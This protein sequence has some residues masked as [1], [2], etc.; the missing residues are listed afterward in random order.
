M[1]S[2]EK[3]TSQY[4]AQYSHDQSLDDRSSTLM[5]ACKLRLLSV[6]AGAPVVDA[7]SNGTQESIGFTLR[8]GFFHM[9]R[10][11]EALNA[12]DRCG[13]KRSYHQR[14]FHEEYLRSATRVFFKTEKPGSFERAHKKVLEI[15]GW[16]SLQQEVLISTPRRFGKTISISLFCAALMFACPAVECS[17][18]STCKRISQKLLRNVCKFLDMIYTEMKVAP[19]KIH[20]KNQE[21]LNIQGPE[22]Q[23]DLRTISSYPSKWYFDPISKCFDSE[24]TTLLIRQLYMQHGSE[25][26][27]P[28][29]IGHSNFPEGTTSLDTFFL[30]AALQYGASVNNELVLN[31]DTGLFG[32]VFT[33]IEGV[34]GEDILVACAAVIRGLSGIYTEPGTPAEIVRAKWCNSIKGGT[35]EPEIDACCISDAKELTTRLFTFQSSRVHSGAEWSCVIEVMMKQLLVHSIPN[36]SESTTLK[37]FVDGVFIIC[38]SHLK[39]A[40]EGSKH[41]NATSF[42]GHLDSQNC[43][44]QGTDNNNNMSKTTADTLIAEVLLW[45]RCFV[46]QR[47]FGRQI[48]ETYF[49]HIVSGSTDNGIEMRV[50]DKSV[51]DG[52]EFDAIIFIDTCWKKMADGAFPPYAITQEALHNSNH[53]FPKKATLIWGP[54]VDDIARFEDRIYTPDNEFNATVLHYRRDLQSMYLLMLLKHRNPY[55]VSWYNLLKP[56]VTGQDQILDVYV[57]TDCL[58]ELHKCFASHLNIDTFNVSDSKW[59]TTVRR[60]HNADPTS[61]TSKTKERLMEFLHGG[62]NTA[63]RR[64]SRVVLPSY[65]TELVAVARMYGFARECCLA[66]GAILPAS[67]LHMPPVVKTARAP[68]TLLRVNTASTGIHIQYDFGEIIACYTAY[69]S[70][71]KDLSRTRAHVAGIEKALDETVKRT[72]GSTIDSSTGIPSGVNEILQNLT[73]PKRYTKALSGLVRLLCGQYASITGEGMFAT[74]KAGIDPMEYWKSWHAKLKFFNSL[75]VACLHTCTSS[76]NQDLTCDTTWLHQR[77]TARNVL[78]EGASNVG[79]LRSSEQRRFV[80]KYR[81]LLLFQELFPGWMDMS[82]SGDIEYTVAQLLQ[83]IPRPD[84]AVETYKVFKAMQCKTFRWTLVNKTHMINAKS[85]VEH[86]ICVLLILFGVDKFDAGISYD[87]V[88]PPLPQPVTTPSA[89]PSLPIAPPSP[90]PAATPAPT[91]EATPAPTPE[92]TP[93]PTPEATP[94]VPKPEQKK[95]WLFS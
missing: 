48:A 16:D 46:L 74:P 37:Q 63:A 3:A 12:L 89:E 24:P 47:T 65:F 50:F 55:I 8:D 40:A 88:M 78:P 70:R 56:G 14:L 20:R 11:R 94:P 35:S 23:G 44:P 64:M 32:I 43:I 39:T 87:G 21:E 1:R 58:S 27:P 71:L 91:P 15:N 69:R 77:H 92:V 59:D 6:T 57:F 19:F 49:N 51:T 18:Y 67:V 54:K 29:S 33:H 13:W 90:T 93:A 28:I 38:K 72:F 85:I 73:K 84:S 79:V 26:A 60:C 95:R 75:L 45:V 76:A 31:T 53:L 30:V 62:N 52:G 86:T 25:G 41:V 4:A 17:I 7:S 81:C 66:T 42:C 2:F 10:L 61:F 82:N 22:G 9:A 80:Y 34:V 36:K 83:C 68:A 5:P